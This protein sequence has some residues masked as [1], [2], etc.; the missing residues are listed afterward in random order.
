MKFTDI[1]IRRPVL[2]TVVSLLI[3]LFGLRAIYDL[4][5]R[6]FPAM[7]N[8]VITVTTAYPGAN[9]DLIQGF[10]TSPLQKSIAGA[11]GIDYLTSEST[12]GASTI[13]AFIKLNYSPQQA[14]TNIMAKVAEVRG[15]LPK[16]SEQPVIQKEAAEG[17][18]LM[19]ISFDSEK[20]SPQQIT[21]YVS[22]VVQP[23]IETISGVSQAQI[24]GGSVFAMR[25]WL[26]PQRM[27][28]LNITASDITNAL[29]QKN[30]QTAAGKTKGEYVA[31]N[32]SATTDL[33]TQQQFENIVV[34][35]ENG[36]LIRLREVAKVR[37]G[38]EN[39]DSLVTFNGKKAV[40]MAINATPTANPLTVI[41]SVRKV[42]PGI[43]NNSPPSL[44]GNIVYDATKFIRVSIDEVITTIV[45]ATIIVI[46]VIFLFLGS[47][48]SVFIPVV[49]IPLSLI[50]VCSLMLALGYSIN[51]LTLLAMVLAIGLV[52]D[53]AIVV[54]ENIHR[55]IEDGLT[56]FKA[57]LQGAREIATP[58]ISMT[59]TLAAVYAPIG[60]MGGL[61][62]ALFKEFAFT[63]ACA[64][65]ISGIIA[66]TLSPMMCSKILSSDASSGRFAHYIDSIFNRIKGFYERRLTNVL[67][68]RSVI[69]VFALVVLTSLFFLYHFSNKETAP[70]ED[71]GFLIVFAQAPQYS[72]IDYVTKFTAE[73]NQIF[74]SIPQVQD[75]FVINGM[76]AVNSVIAGLVLKPWDERSKTATQLNEPLQHQVS[77][78]AGLQSFIV[79]P[80]SL[81]GTE[82]GAPVQFV[83]TSTSDYKLIYPVAEKIVAAAQKSGLFIFV[84]NTLMFN[85]PMYTLKINRNK[86]ANLNIN[87]E[88]IGNSLSTALAG[89]YINRFSM[90]GQSYK[91]IPQLQR[92][93]RARQRQLR[94]L[95]VR[96]GSGAM[97]PLATI[98]TISESTEPNSL[99]QFQQ[100][101]SATIQ[102]MLK[103]GVSMGEALSF[104]QKEAKKELPRGMSYN[105]LGQSRQF[106]EEGSALMYTFFFA[107][108]VIFLVLAAQFESFADP[109][110]VLIS[111][112]MSICGA[113]IPLNLGFASVNIY[114]Q[115]GMITLIGLI[116]K[117]GILMVDFANHLQS[118]KGFSIHKAIIEAASVR[119]RPILMTTGAM[120]FGVFPLIFATGAG[121]VSRY[122]IGLVIAT[123]MFIGTAFTLFVVPTMYTLLAKDH[124]KQAD[125]EQLEVDIQPK[126]A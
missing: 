34:K 115:V 18:A 1:F 110:I 58:V 51:L 4:P 50:G 74:K 103:P 41:S 85:K 92:S 5:V 10:I 20:M 105:Y 91:V 73:F 71:E 7:E 29:Q 48:R 104:L 67:K 88:N 113:L 40:F 80:P 15:E 60:F 72:T 119:L 22:R 26:N 61:T 11:D 90:E 69:I 117:H 97:V 59:L 68:Y 55:H 37:L 122:N 65:I 47:L 116:S 123:G 38:S 111:V 106:I 13:K 118:E 101:N 12:Q 87:I 2:A 25:I 126:Q 63:L 108:I 99:T 35:N 86:A 124:T 43:F 42:L 62:G 3:L 17:S 125:Q 109:F 70:Q 44:T 45:E 54:V 120:I 64:V 24:L 14:F 89:G 95:Y 53:D 52:V 66:L 96:T 98:A 56:P 82:G 121:A 21:D 75:Y 83:I 8:T 100:L 49:T 6:Q 107:I 76:G 27:G 28:A 32:V 30:F 23:E 36:S 94:E 112:P 19:Y 102:G 114:T 57:A 78:I 93:F 16:N 39:Y 84:N 46:I 81:P 33:H 79:Q 9:A 77:Q 31:V